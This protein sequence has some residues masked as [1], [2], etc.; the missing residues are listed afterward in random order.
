MS[1]S[2][3][4]P[5]RGRWVRRGRGIVLLPP[6][7]GPAL[8]GEAGWAGEMEAGSTPLLLPHY[9]VRKAVPGGA[10]SPASGT[11][12]RMAPA[13]MTPGYVNASDELAVNTGPSGLHTRLRELVAKSYAR[14]AGKMK[15]ALVD[16]TGTRLYNPDF[17]GWNSTVLLYGASTPKICALYG[18]RQLGFD[19]Q[20]L[21]RRDGIQKKDALVA[22]ARKAWAAAGLAAKAQPAVEELF[23]FAETSGSPVAVTASAKLEK[24][25]TC[26]FADNCNWAASLLIDRV[27]H[28]FINSVL[29]QSGLFHP[30]RGGLWM[31]TLY[32]TSGNCCFPKEKLQKAVT[33]AP[34][35]PGFRGSV[36]NQSVSALSLATFFTLMAQGRL[37]SDAVSGRMLADL[38]PACSFF[39]GSGL[40]CDPGF[41]PPSKCGIWNGYVHDGILIQRPTGSGCGGKTIRYAVALLTQD[42]SGA[43]KV[44]KPF[45]K[46]V[47]TLIQANNP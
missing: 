8:Q 45:L 42:L 25:I 37:A 23:D 4:L 34:A 47:D 11:P 12:Q 16:L 22:A 14:Q 26:T 21:A 6:P 41:T 9:H 18:A 39:G 20:A 15:V 1:V 44:F 19:L 13:G 35:P 17:A 36:P 38:Q 33:T 3:S 29:W 40:P 2:S 10:L 46:D 27:G 31:R 5:T 24:L 28:G 43:A 7:P 32:G 30:G